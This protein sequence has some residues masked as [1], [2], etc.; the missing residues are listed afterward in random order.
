MADQPSAPIAI[1]LACGENRDY[2]YATRRSSRCEIAGCT[3][4]DSDASSRAVKSADGCFFGGV[5]KWTKGTDCK[6]VIRGFESHRRLLLERFGVHPS[7]FLRSILF[8]D[9]NDN[10]QSSG[11]SFIGPFARRFR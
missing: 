9:E 6:S 1:R 8:G 4:S 10:E 11:E 5:P 3:R 2:R 7:D